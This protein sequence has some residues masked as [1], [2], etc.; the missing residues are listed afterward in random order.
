MREIFINPGRY[1][2]N[3]NALERLVDGILTCEGAPSKLR[4]E[5]TYTDDSYIKKLNSE[6]LGRN[7]PTDCM[8][9]ILPDEAR[10]REIADIYISYDRAVEQAKARKETL[11]F[12]LA[13]L[14]AHGV[15]HAVGYGDD[16]LIEEKQEDY[17]NRFFSTRTP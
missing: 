9:F 2:I 11:D 7:Y 15:L 14:T 1:D 16:K 12:E 3:V 13:I 5:I 8:C 4:I 6:Y 10:N 17:A